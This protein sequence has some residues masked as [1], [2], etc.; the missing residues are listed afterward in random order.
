MLLEEKHDLGHE[1]LC[2]RLGWILKEADKIRD[3]IT[4][5]RTLV[6]QGAGNTPGRADIN[7]CVGQALSLL[8]AQLAAHGITL[9]LAL[10]DNL[11]PVK[12]NPV[13]LEQV[14]IN[15]AVNAM[16]A[17]DTLEPAAESEKT[18]FIETNRK[19]EYIQLL[20]GG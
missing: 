20:G 1:T 10:E 8:K 7:D 3:I 9:C 14:I 18:L 15:L 6:H 19:N 13:Q 4:H 5:M 17:L 2:T 11:P 16:Q 12:A